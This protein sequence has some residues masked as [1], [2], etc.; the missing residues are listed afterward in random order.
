MRIKKLRASCR[1]PRVRE[2]NK[3]DVTGLAN[4][5]QLR[6][7]GIHRSI[8]YLFGGAVTLRLRNCLGPP[9]MC[10]LGEALQAYLEQLLKA[11]VTRNIVLTVVWSMLAQ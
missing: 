11:W 4:C 10:P 6:Q 7:G 8:D 1:Y 3:Y 9:Y 5:I 2:V